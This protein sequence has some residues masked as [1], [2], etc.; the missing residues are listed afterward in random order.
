MNQSE[1]VSAWSHAKTSCSMCKSICWHQRRRTCACVMGH[2]R[3]M[4]WMAHQRRGEVAPSGRARPRARQHDT[5]AS[6]GDG[7]RVR[8]PVSGFD[9]SGKE[10]ASLNGIN[11]LLHA[12]LL[13]WSGTLLRSSTRLLLAPL[14]GVSRPSSRQALDHHGRY[15]RAI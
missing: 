5:W 13:F 11:A 4:S 15:A 1:N 2:E 14:L 12:T 7:D 10:K 9:R 6:E 3:C 8:R